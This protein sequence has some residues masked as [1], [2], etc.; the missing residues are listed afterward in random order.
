MMS[1]LVINIIFIGEFM[2][3][4]FSVDIL[5]IIRDILSKVET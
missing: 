2:D 4:S 1:F 5:S 3:Y